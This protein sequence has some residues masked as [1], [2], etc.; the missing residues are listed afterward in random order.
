MGGST[1]TDIQHLYHMFHFV[2]VSVFT[3][4]HLDLTPCSE[5]VLSFFNDTKIYFCA[6]TAHRTTHG[7]CKSW[8]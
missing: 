2:N 5:D 1:G 4:R 7:E 8:R 3:L 6:V